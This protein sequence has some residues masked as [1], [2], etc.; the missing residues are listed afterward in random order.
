[1]TDRELWLMSLQVGVRVRMSHAKLPD[2]DMVI[3][4][5][6]EHRFHLVAADR[7]KSDLADG[8]TIWRAPGAG[9]MFRIDPVDDGRLGSIGDEPKAITGAVPLDATLGWEAA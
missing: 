3:R 7:P 9:G 1:M 5:V 2:R 4:A 6:D 8:V